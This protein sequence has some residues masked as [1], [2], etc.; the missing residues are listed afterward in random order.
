VYPSRLRRNERAAK[1]APGSRSASLWWCWQSR[2]RLL[3][4]P[5]RGGDESTAAASHAAHPGA[6]AHSARPCISA[7]RTAA[8][9]DGR[10]TRGRTRHALRGT[11]GRPRRRPDTLLADRGYDS[12]Q[13][14]QALR[15]RGIRPIIARRNTEHGSRLGGERWVVERTL[16]WLHQYRRLRIRYERRYPR[17][18]RQPR[19]GCWRATGW[20]RGVGSLSLPFR[21]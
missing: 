3:G 7:S 21:A 14:R 11:R 2:T 13:H 1:R 20:S 5:V 17:S 19:P 9:P 16:S 8:D 4:S 18:L 6:T 10:R 15:T 12:Q